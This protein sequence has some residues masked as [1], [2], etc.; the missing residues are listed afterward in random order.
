M[1][2]IEN[3]KKIKSVQSRALEN[4]IVMQSLAGYLDAHNFKYVFTEFSTPGK[5]KDTNFD[6]V[7]Y[8]PSKLHNP[9]VTLV[10]N[11]VPNL[12]DWALPELD[13]YKTNKGGDG[14]HPDSDQHLSWTRSVLLPYL[15]ECV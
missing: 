3:I 7:P 6:P 2:S 8:L 15:R 10:R 11:V 1:V 9:F 14:Y 12:G 5:M 13:Y 4:Y